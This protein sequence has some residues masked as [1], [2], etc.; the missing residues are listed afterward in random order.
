[1][2]KLLSRMKRLEETFEAK[3]PTS[4]VRYCFK[5]PDETKEQAITRAGINP[6]TEDV[7]VIVLKWV[8]PKDPEYPLYKTRKKSETVAAIDE[9]INALKNELLKSGELTAQQ[10]AELEAKHHDTKSI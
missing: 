7:I 2:N 8:D 9:K 1:M 5:L 6:D 10:V 4:Q 3:K